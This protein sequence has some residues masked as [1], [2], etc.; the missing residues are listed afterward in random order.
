MWRPV[1]ALAVGA[2]AF[3]NVRLLFYKSLTCSLLPEA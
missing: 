1:N 3:G 2:T